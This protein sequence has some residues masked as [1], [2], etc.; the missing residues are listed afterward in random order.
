M[1]SPIIVF[2]YHG[3]SA[4]AARRILTSG[5]IPSERA[6]D[7]LGDGV[8]FWQDAPFRAWEW[9]RQRHPEQPAVVRSVLELRDCMDLLD[10]FW[11]PALAVIYTEYV[12]HHLASGKPLP[13]QSSASKNRRRDRDVFNQAVMDLQQQGIPIRVVRGAFQEG[14]PI[15]PESGI[16]DRSHVQIAVRDASLISETVRIDEH[17]RIIQ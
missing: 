12:A 5:Y 15:Y 9:A 1:T 3:T 11:Y 13:R 7:W 16:H 17:G 4:E 10:T 2:G 8:Y 6:W 14:N